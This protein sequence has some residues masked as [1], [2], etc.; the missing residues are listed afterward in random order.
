MPWWS[1]EGA[2]FWELDVVLFWDTIHKGNL[3]RV[4]KKNV[5]F[6]RLGVSIFR[7]GAFVWE[8][9]VYAHKPFKVRRCSLRGGV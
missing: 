2:L 3:R 1:E 9:R 5:Q 8:S 7:G 4:L 6:S